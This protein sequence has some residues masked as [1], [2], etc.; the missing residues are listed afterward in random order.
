MFFIFFKSMGKVLH[1]KT[2][3]RSLTTPR[4]KS[5]ASVHCLKPLLFYLG[6][7]AL[8]AN[9]FMNLIKNKDPLF[10]PLQAV[11]YTHLFGDTMSPT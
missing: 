4:S 6:L 7:A 3:L 8:I 10:A 2:V 5:Y 11:S 1:F 9:K